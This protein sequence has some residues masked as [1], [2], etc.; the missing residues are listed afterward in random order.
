MTTKPYRIVAKVKNNRLWSA[1]I[2]VYPNCQNQ[3]DAARVFKIHPTQFG[4]LINMKTWPARIEDGEIIWSPLA[5]RIAAHLGVEPDFIFDPK[6]YGRNI[7][8]PRMIE[9]EVGVKELE[10]RGVM[11][12][13][14][15]AE[16][17]VAAAQLK[18]VVRHVLAEG[19]TP[20]EEQVARMF[21]GIGE[22]CEY[23]LKEIAEKF[24]VGVPR[25][26]QIL[27]KVN[28][29]LRHPRNARHLQQFMGKPLINRAM[30]WSDGRDETEEKSVKPGGEC[31]AC[32]KPSINSDNL[33]ALHAHCHSE[34]CSNDCE[35]GTVW[36]VE[37]NPVLNFCV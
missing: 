28:E 32:D 16:E 6:F 5:K 25:I 31:L 34:D 3:S 33:C 29:K 23:S 8:V 14:P 20:K 4:V 7:G 12:L 27:D 15:P 17:I 1:L 18:D 2:A 24:G 26:R 37:H 36:C 30:M 35:S 19:L 22:P 9:L 13:P 10:H 11:E 21:F